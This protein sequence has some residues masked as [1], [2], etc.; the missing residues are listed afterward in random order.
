MVHRYIIVKPLRV[1]TVSITVSGVTRS[2]RDPHQFYDRMVDVLRSVRA[3]AAQRFATF[4]IG[5]AQAKIL[6]HIGKN[7]RISQADLARAT[8]TAPTLTGRA[9][10]PLVERGWVR[11][12][13]SEEDR[14][15]YVLE[16]TAEGKRVRDKVEEARSQIID[17]ITS[18]LDDR[19]IDD[20]DRISA[21][22]LA[23]LAEVQAEH[24]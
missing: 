21:K 16:L 18:T 2:R 19:D 24:D 1:G 23:V 5:S 17:R 12:K 7:S 13:R 8:D 9:I 4:E 22:L 11:R 10:E 14:R 3:A 6:R 20:F 15:E